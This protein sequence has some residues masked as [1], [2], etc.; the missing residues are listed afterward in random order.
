MYNNLQQNDVR[1]F[2]FDVYD[3]YMNNI[4]LSSLELIALEVIQQHK[5]YLPIIQQKE[6]YLNYQWL[7]ESGMTNPFLHMSMHISIK[8]QLSIN[9]PVGV[10]DYYNQLLNK[11]LD[12]M[13]VEHHIMDCLAEMIWYSQKNQV[14]FD[15]SIYFNCLIDKIK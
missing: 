9:Q 5:E 13:V 7:P 10:V 15:V 1:I 11:Y 2:F 6:K 12:P 4:P 14:P 3:K 8:E